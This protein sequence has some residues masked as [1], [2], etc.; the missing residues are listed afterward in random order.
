MIVAQQL[1]VNWN[2]KRIVEKL[3]F[4]FK[5]DILSS[6]SAAKVLTVNWTL[7]NILNKE[8]SF[9]WDILKDSIFVR[10]CRNYIYPCADRVA[11]CVD[12][13][14]VL[15]AK[16][17]SNNLTFKWNLGPV[18]SFLNLKWDQNLSIS[19][20]TSPIILN[21]NLGIL[22]CYATPLANYSYVGT[23]VIIRYAYGMDISADG[24]H[25]L[26]A[27]AIDQQVHLYSRTSGQPFDI[28]DL[29]TGYRGVFYVNEPVDILPNDTVGIQWKPDGSGFFAT[30]TQF[31]QGKLVEWNL[32]GAPYSIGAG[33]GFNN[34]EPYPRVVKTREMGTDG[35]G[36]ESVGNFRISPDGTKMLGRINDSN[37]SIAE[38]VM[39][40]PW[41]IG[42]M[43]YVGKQNGSLGSYGGA[44]FVSN[45]G[46]CIYA[47]GGLNSGDVRLFNNAENPWESTIDALYQDIRDMDPQISNDFSSSADDRIDA[48]WVNDK[49]MYVTQGTPGGNP[50]DYPAGAYATYIHHYS[51]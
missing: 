29:T 50:N 21:W 17:V 11:P 30:H 7:L 39:S 42:T 38:Y 6:L 51:T 22:P 24:N 10:E 43:T 19:T 46:T 13:C 31:T 26:I 41:D 32:P 8:Y 33:S 15:S 36:A 37:A 4:R 40:T 25:L 49:H 2:L 45:D 20:E 3:N 44:T 27:N 23:G 18:I 28:V 12:K 34:V 48:I 1:I 5:W 35:N 9:N 47:S 16:K 14:P